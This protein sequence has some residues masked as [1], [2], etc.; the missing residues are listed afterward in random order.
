M[1]LYSEPFLEQIQKWVQNESLIPLQD[2]DEIAD[3]LGPVQIF[4]S[5]IEPRKPRGNEFIKNKVVQ[6]IISK[7]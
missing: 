4:K 5:T 2:G 1:S 6:K 7:F 3:F